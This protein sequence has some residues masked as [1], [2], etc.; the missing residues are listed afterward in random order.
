MEPKVSETERP[1]AP[2]FPTPAASLRPLARQSSVASATLKRAFRPPDISS[3]TTLPRETP[4][5]VISA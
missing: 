5:L 2:G 1:L 4:A 3:T